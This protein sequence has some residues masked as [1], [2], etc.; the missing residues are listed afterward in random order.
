MICIEYYHI[1][2]V[3]PNPDGRS[4]LSL[5]H[6]PPLTRCPGFRS[7]LR[8]YHGLAAVG[9]LQHFGGV[10]LGA[11]TSGFAS[12]LEELQKELRAMLP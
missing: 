12:E 11:E 5:T 1:R 10:Q 6:Q 4:L 8:Q 9:Q 3:L 7:P 2:K